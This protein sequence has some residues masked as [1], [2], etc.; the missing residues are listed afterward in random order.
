MTISP[1]LA[2]LIGSVATALSIFGG[3][4]AVEAY[5]RH[6][7]RLGM[8]LALAGAFDAILSLIETRSMIPHLLASLPDL[9]RGVRVEFSSLIHENASFKAITSAYVDQIG[10]LGGDLPFRTAGFMTNVDMLTQDLVRL[11][12]HSDRPEAQAL[13]IRSMG[14]VW[15]NTLLI[16]TALV[17]DL[18]ERGGVKAAPRQRTPT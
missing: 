15:D 1:G 3:G 5:K 17:R 14:P 10:H 12:T 13:L 18:R 4:L 11:E 7:D 6:R 2:A 16:G 9:E 8:A